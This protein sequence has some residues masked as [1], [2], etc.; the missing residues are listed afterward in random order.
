MNTNMAHRDGL[1][2]HSNA[3]SRPFGA[4]MSNM[5]GEELSRWIDDEYSGLSSRQSTAGVPVNIRETDKTYEVEVIA[6]GLKKSDFKVAVDGRQLS[7]SFEHSAHEKEGDEK[8]GYLR[9][10][11]RHRSFS[12]SFMLD[13][14]MDANK[15]SAGYT[16]GVLHLHVPKKEEAQRIV[17]HVD[18]K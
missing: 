8:K 17:R 13:D 4:L 9:Q 2:P 11:F 10:E 1:H 3:L 7:I 15:I 14:T 12:R 6:P 5:L 18:I 16:D